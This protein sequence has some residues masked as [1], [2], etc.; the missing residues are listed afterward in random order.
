MSLGVIPVILTLTDIE[1]YSHE[2]L[3]KVHITKILNTNLHI[4][5]FSIVLK[6]FSESYFSLFFQELVVFLDKMVSINTFIE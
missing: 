2:E 6:C 5:R 3:C 4:Y 1:E